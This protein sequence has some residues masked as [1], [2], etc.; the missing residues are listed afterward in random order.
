M[1]KTVLILGGTNEARRLADQLVE[2]FHDQLRVITSLAG[3]TKS[4]KHPKGDIREGGFGG[5]DG[6]ASYLR[7]SKIDMVI[8]ATHPYAA[9]IT[10][11]ATEAAIRTRTPFIILSRPAWEQ[12]ADDT[13]INVPDIASAADALSDTLGKVLI[14]TGVQNLAAFADLKDTKLLVRL[15][16]QPETKIPIDA[17]HILYGKPPY[18]LDEEVALYKLLGIDAIVTKNAGSLATY[19]KIEAARNLGLT[20]IMIDRPALPK[21]LDRENIVE[22]IDQI[23]LR[24]KARLGLSS[25]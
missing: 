15:I 6:L 4:P 1:Q 9:Q 8:D 11:H 16:E 14:T 20:V 17:A 24:I 22:D 5:P 19:A 3:R 12:K 13:W 2:Q 23:L 21:T 25:D 10:E 7:E 18:K